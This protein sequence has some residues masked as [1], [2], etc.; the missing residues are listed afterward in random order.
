MN[1]SFSKIR[2]IQEA[3]QRLEK[4]KLNEQGGFFFD[5]AEE[6]KGPDGN[7]DLEKFDARMEKFPKKPPTRKPEEGP[8]ASAGEGWYDSEE[9]EVMEPTDYS[10]EKTFGP[11]D[12]E[13]F[14][15]YINNCNT[16]WCLTTKRM[17]DAYSKKPGG[18]KVRK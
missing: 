17:Y 6:L 15:E 4:R 2:H 16:K 11:D 14:M 1:R 7:I 9:M 18:I 10:E 3:N 12:Y 13:N 5:D 8:F